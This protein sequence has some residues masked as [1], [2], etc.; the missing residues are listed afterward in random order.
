MATAQTAWPRIIAVRAAKTGHLARWAGAASGDITSKEVD[1]AGMG[2]TVW[3]T[4]KNNPSQ[5][6]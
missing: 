4:V 3:Q 2:R 5:G 6:Y 1:S